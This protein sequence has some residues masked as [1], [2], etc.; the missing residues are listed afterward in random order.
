MA[1]GFQDDASFFLK[2]RVAFPVL[3]DEPKKRPRRGLFALMN[4]SRRSDAP[5]ASREPQG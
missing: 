1:Y 5:A 2:N 4:L 3:G